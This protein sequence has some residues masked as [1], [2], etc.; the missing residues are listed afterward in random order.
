MVLGINPLVDNCS[1]HLAHPISE[2]A[3]LPSAGCG[4]MKAQAAARGSAITSHV[5]T[6]GR[7]LKWQAAGS[8]TADVIGAATTG[9]DRPLNAG[10][11]PG[12]AAGEALAP[13]RVS[14]VPTDG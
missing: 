10:I 4:I 12:E 8:G 3:A 14:Q 13:A 7:N 5:P 6:E 9:A 2:F 11:A 1:Q